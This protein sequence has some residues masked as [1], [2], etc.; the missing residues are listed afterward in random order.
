MHGQDEARLHVIIPRD[1]SN[2]VKTLLENARLI[3]NYRLVLA[4]YSLELQN[5]DR[6]ESMLFS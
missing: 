6:F 2:E 4:S 5:A 1:A 3:K